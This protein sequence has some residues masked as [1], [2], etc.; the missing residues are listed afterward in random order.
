MYK[1]NKSWLKLSS[2]PS[3]KLTLSLGQFLIWIYGLYNSNILL[4]GKTWLTRV[5]HWTYGLLLRWSPFHCC[6]KIPDTHNLKRWSLFFGSW[7]EKFSP[8]ST[9]LQKHHSKTVQWRK[10]CSIH[11]IREAEIKGTMKQQETRDQIYSPILHL[12]A[13]PDIPRNVLY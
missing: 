5:L 9:G 7:F 4:H 13:H 12:M 6:D 2:L 8:W 10:S 11:G 1:T 3:A